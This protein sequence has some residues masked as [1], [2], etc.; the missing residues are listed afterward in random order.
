[1]GTKLVRLVFWGSVLLLSDTLATSSTNYEAAR[2]DGPINIRKVI[3][4][5]RHAMC[6]LVEK[7]VALFKGA[8]RILG[9]NTP[10][11]KGRRDPPLQPRELVNL[12]QYG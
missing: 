6:Q 1:M 4:V 3:S 5:Q 10:S 2:E 8:L 11:R 7:V 9:L 12:S